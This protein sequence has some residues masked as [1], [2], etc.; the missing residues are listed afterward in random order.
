MAINCFACADFGR[1]T[2]RARFS[3]ASLDSG[4]SEKSM[5]LSGIGLPLFPARLPRADDADRFFAIGHPIIV[6]TLILARTQA[7]RPFVRRGGQLFAY[8]ELSMKR[9]TLAKG[10]ATRQSQRMRKAINQNLHSNGQYS[11]GLFRGVARI[12]FGI[13]CTTHPGLYFLDGR[14]S[15]PSQV[16]TRKTQDETA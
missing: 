8:V 5:R 7:G 14:P 16:R 10:R 15:P 11:W 9:A 6:Y 12:L 1:P 3:S 4:I 13:Q 2:R